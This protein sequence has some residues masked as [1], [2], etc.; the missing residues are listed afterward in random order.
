M[1]YAVVKT[2]GKQYKVSQGSILEI[3]RLNRQKDD[4]VIL[5]NVLLWV[6]DGQV[7]IGKPNLPNIKIKTRVIENIKGDKIRVA[8]FKAKARY[9]RMMGFRPH[10]TKLEIKSIDSGNSIVKAVKSEIKA[11]KTPLKKLKSAGKIKK[12]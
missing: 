1:E 9:R 3:D 2:G 10:I 6:C 4:E 8:K 11:Q 12:S 7:K 5:D